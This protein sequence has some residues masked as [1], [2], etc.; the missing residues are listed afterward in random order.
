M[1]HLIIAHRGASGLELENSLPAFKKALEL[2]VPMIEF[3]VR[4]TADGQLIV[5]HDPDLG[6]VSGDNRLIR[7]NTYKDLQDIC[8]KNGSRALS[9]AD[10]LAIVSKTPVMIELKDAGSA[11][12]LLRVLAKFPDAQAS[13]TS[14]K[15]KELIK[16]RELRPQLPVYA[17]TATRAVHTIRQAHEHK[18]TGVALHFWLINPFTYWLARRHELDVYVWTVN[19]RW[20]ARMLQIL[21]PHVS[22]CTNFPNKFIRRPQ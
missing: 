20:H 15:R 16:L 21:Y 6:R 10:A 11:E 17:L 5:S 13:I 12:T 2:G 19:N 4:L 7:R 1:K 22:I 9:L 14:F 8:L 3:D 18:L